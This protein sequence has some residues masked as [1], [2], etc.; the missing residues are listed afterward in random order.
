MNES[1]YT[2][3]QRELWQELEQKA[4]LIP[5]ERMAIYEAAQIE[6]P[7][8]SVITSIILQGGC[9]MKLPDGSDS[10]IYLQTITQ[11][12]E[13]F[14]AQIIFNYRFIVGRGP[15]PAAAVYVAIMEN[16]HALTSPNP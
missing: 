14:Y 8:A 1:D 9:R 3:H 12:D 11:G 16:E 5:P 6:G 4:A 15:S 7:L 2:D 13:W 10:R